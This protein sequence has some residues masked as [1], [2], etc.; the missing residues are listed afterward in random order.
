MR[1]AGPFASSGRLASFGRLHG[2]CQKKIKIPHLVKRLTHGGCTSFSYL[3][4]ILILLTRF[5]IHILGVIFSILL[6]AV[7]KT[8]FE[9]ESLLSF[10]LQYTEAL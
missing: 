4:N 5:I 6:P 8:N 9:V 3:H 7:M 10:N 1:R 2:K